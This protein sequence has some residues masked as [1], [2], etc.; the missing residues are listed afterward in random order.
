MFNRFVSPRMTKVLLFLGF[1]MMAG[2]LGYHFAALD[3][4]NFFV[5]NN[6]KARF[7]DKDVA[8]GTHPRHRLDVFAPREG[9]G[10]WPVVVFVHGG[11]WQDGNKRPYAFVGRALAGQGFVAMVIN[12]RL[13][14][15]GRYPGFVE[16]TALALQWARQNAGDYGGDTRHIFAMGHSAG[17]Y[18]V[19]MA[20]L[21]RPDVKLSG[22]I[23]LAG[24]FDFVPLDTRVTKKVF[25]HVADLASTQPINRVYAGAPP[26]LILHGS[27]DRTVLL[28]NATALAAALLAQG[29]EADMKMYDSV[30][31]VGILLGLARRADKNPVL[32]DAVKF[33]REKAR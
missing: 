31:H 15:E 17:G 23:S 2:G 5:P 26:F 22:V 30:S 14:P 16:D 12:Y 9:K 3:I 8:Y 1:M 4:F 21:T 13:H 27:Q 28:R 20:A 33:M 19:A 6:T 29:V 7:V 24:P 11:S 32:Q 18:N 10:P 25:S